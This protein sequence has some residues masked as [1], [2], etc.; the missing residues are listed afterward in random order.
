MSA[1]CI[2]RVRAGCGSP[3]IFS[4]QRSIDDALYTEIL[5][6]PSIVK[7]LSSESS[8]HCIRARCSGIGH[9][10]V[11]GHAASSDSTGGEISAGLD[12]ASVSPPGSAVTHRSANLSPP[13]SA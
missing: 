11:L 12:V 13:R 2:V 1:F 5:D 6:F 8:L 4:N 10:N 7:R 9:G 3:S